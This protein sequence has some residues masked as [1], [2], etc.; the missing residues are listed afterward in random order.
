MKKIWMIVWCLCLTGIAFGQE[1]TL[2]VAERN[3]LQGFN[4][5]IDRLAEDFVTVNLV[6]CDP[7][8]VLYS[9]LGHAALHLQCP[10]F[11]LDY[12]YTYESENVRDK[13]YGFR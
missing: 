10:T 3:A 9:T 5:T 13:I 1:D 6:V 8:T 12:I 11:G 2:S 7:G 4:D